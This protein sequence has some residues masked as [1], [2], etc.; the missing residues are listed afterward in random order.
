[1]DKFF[2]IKLHERCRDP[3]NGIHTMSRFNTQD[4]K[5]SNYNYKEVWINTY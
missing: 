1:M 5:S 4:I 2:K 3:L